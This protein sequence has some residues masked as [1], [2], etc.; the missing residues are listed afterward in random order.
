VNPAAD[1]QFSVSTV[2]RDVYVAFYR[3]SCGV[4]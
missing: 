3:H 2:Y 4:P 1:P